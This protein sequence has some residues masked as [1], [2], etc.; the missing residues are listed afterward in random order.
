MH[1]LRRIFAPSARRKL[2]VLA[3]ALGAV[4]LMGGRA[5]EGEVAIVSLPYLFGHS[6]RSETF[7]LQ[8]VRLLHNL[9]F[10]VCYYLNSPSELIDVVR[11]IGM[12]G[13]ID[14]ITFLRTLPQTTENYILL[15]DE[16]QGELP[17]RNW[18][19]VLHLHLDLSTPIHDAPDLIYLPFPDRSVGYLL[20]QVEHARCNPKTM[21][22][23]FAGSWIGYRNHEVGTLLGKMEREE[24]VRTFKEYPGTRTLRTAQEVEAVL[25]GEALSPCGYYFIDTQW[26]RVPQAE[27]FR[28]LSHAHV[29]LCPPGIHHPMSHNIVEAMAVGT[30]PLTNYPEWFHPPL[31]HG[32]NC[33]TF[34]DEQSLLSLLQELRTRSDDELSRIRGNTLAYYD[35]YLAPR[36]R[37]EDI[38]RRLLDGKPS[39]H[40]AMSTEIVEFFPHLQ[41]DSIR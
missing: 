20:D 3:R 16:G 5:P 15:C 23:L 24:I 38:R 41:D 29:F 31:A 10:R 40:L 2:G 18:R 27:W 37:E 35:E 25:S 11:A 36:Q 32:V 12:H 1:N 39:S 19:H 34:E 14:R 30:I 7:F 21:R 26:Y 8:I 4:Y 28:V 22:L 13:D 9:G 17:K 33:F 6:G